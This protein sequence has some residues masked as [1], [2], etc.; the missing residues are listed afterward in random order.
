[1]TTAVSLWKDDGGE[2]ER[3][4]R[5][6]TGLE[7]MLPDTFRSSI[8]HLGTSR[9]FSHTVNKEA[10]TPPATSLHHRV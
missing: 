4:R 1:M 6:K 10:R 5:K 9:D 2:K 8:M 3:R 7:Q